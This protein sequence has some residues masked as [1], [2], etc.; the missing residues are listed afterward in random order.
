MNQTIDKRWDEALARHGAVVNSFLE[1]AAAVEEEAWHTPIGEGKWTP[2]QIAEHLILTYTTLVRQVQGGQGLR[3]QTGWLLRHVLRV[4]VLA[5]IMWL[6]KIPPGAKAP[7][8]LRPGGDAT[9][10]EV[11]LERLRAAAAE[12]EDEIARRRDDKELRLTHHVFGSVKPLKGI[13][14]VAI[15]T[16][17]HGRQLRVG[18][19]RRSR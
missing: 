9:T 11:S 13:N 19:D 12:F 16:E 17:H 1:S 7:R 10:R 15:H 4:L 5:P 8:D 2:A 3:V 6:R 18:S 14:F